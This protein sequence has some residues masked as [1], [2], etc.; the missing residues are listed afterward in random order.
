[1]YVCMYVHMHAQTSM[2]ECMYVCMYV[3][4]YIYM[5]VCVYIH[6]SSIHICIHTFTCTHI[7]QCVQALDLFIADTSTSPLRP[8]SPRVEFRFSRTVAVALNMSIVVP[9]VDTDA[10]PLPTLSILNTIEYY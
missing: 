2:H 7:L 5:Y 1:M 8:V 4:I 10:P 6:I 9:D 3:C